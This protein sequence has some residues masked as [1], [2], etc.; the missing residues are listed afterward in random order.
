MKKVAPIREE[1]PNLGRKGNLSSQGLPEVHQEVHRSLSLKRPA[2]CMKGSVSGCYGDLGRLPA[3]SQLLG[4]LGD[5]TQQV[6]L[7]FMGLSF[8]SF[9]DGTQQSWGLLCSPS[10]ESS[11]HVIV[12]PI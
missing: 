3:T 4:S 6:F 10:F 7:C 1:L 12:A 5:F 9:C 8:C 11:R 2:N